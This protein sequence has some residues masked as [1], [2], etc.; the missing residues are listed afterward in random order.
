MSNYK[1]SYIIKTKC[2]K[3]IVLHKDVTKVVHIMKTSETFDMANYI[4]W[5]LITLTLRNACFN[6][7]I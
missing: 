6:V 2:M 4:M 3:K 1:L 5:V 7:R